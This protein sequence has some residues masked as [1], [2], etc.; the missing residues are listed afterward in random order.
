MYKLTGWKQKYGEER[1][2]QSKRHER[3][4]KKKVGEKMNGKKGGFV[5]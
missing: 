2:R 3:K 5:S 4:E 1:E